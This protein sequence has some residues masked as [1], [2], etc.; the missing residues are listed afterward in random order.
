MS[1]LAGLAPIRN[2]HDAIICIVLVIV[3]SGAYVFR[4][5]AK[6]VTYLSFHKREARFKNDS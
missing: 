4:T 3:L 6:R 2:W 5:L 1:L